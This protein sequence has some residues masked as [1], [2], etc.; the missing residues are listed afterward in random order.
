ME[1]GFKER[2]GRFG[3]EREAV[4]G[5]GG[6]RGGDRAGALRAS[7]RAALPMTSA[8]QGK[9]KREGERGAASMPLRA[10]ARGEK[11]EDARSLLAARAQAVGPGEDGVGGTE[12]REKERERRVWFCYYPSRNQLVLI[13]AMA[14]ICSFGRMW[15]ERI[16]FICS[17]LPGRPK[18]PVTK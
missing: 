2:L 6:A 17:S 9:A 8:G 14:Y 4:H 11:R 10:R 16:G 15:I 12:R 13:T 7:R 1:R 18:E 3:G 5:G